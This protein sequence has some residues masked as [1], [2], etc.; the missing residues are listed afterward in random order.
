MGGAGGDFLGHEE[1][2]QDSRDDQKHQEDSLCATDRHG[3][4]HRSTIE[5][6][7]DSRPSCWMRRSGSISRGGAYFVSGPLAGV[8]TNPVGSVFIHPCIRS[9]ALQEQFHLTLLCKYRSMEASAPSGTGLNAELATFVNP[10]PSS[11]PPQI[12]ANV[13]TLSYFAV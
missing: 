1:G 3:R 8:F 4:N 12:D 2:E 7:R 11:N 9:C 10:T 6:P 5:Q 13:H